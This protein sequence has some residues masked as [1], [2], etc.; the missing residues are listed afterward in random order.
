MISFKFNHSEA[1]STSAQGRECPQRSGKG[2]TLTELVM[3]IA[4]IGI[5][6]AIGGNTY[7][8]QRNSFQ[9]ND[10]L[11][12]TLDIIK[13]ARNY[14]VTSQAYWDG[15]TSEIPEEGYGVFIDK[16]NKRFVLF[17]NISTEGVKAD[18]YDS[19]EGFEEEY[20][21][22]QDTEFIDLKGDGISVNQ[23][24]IIFRPPL[25]DATITDNS[26]SPTDIIDLTLE[27][28]RLGAPE[29]ASSKIIKINKVS[30]FPEIE[31]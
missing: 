31:L 23:A 20:T 10:S 14:A 25:A 30:G 1:K 3:V 6:F 8:N 26:A 21:L 22:P 4:I 16:D 19:D 18:Q 15:T 24:V 2:F 28:K 29:E 5:L 9:F 27:L 11:T 17:A 13:T 7:R 12:K